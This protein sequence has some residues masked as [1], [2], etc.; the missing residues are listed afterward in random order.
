MPGLIP[1]ILEKKEKSTNFL[2]M[3]HLAMLPDNIFP[4]EAMP[5]VSEW[6]QW[7]ELQAPDRHPQ[8]E[9][10]SAFRSVGKW[11]AASEGHGLL[12]D[13]SE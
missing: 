10:P 3:D 2:L 4:L 11:H 7:W 9:L 5:S 1:S 6:L 8:S 12:V 13:R